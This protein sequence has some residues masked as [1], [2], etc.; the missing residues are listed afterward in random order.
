MRGNVEVA[1]AA[2]KQLGLVT[3]DEIRKAGIHDRSW[4]LCVKSGLWV[5][6]APRVYRSASVSPTFTQRCLAQVLS[7]GSD[8]TI[9]H[10]SAAF[11]LGLDNFREERVIHVTTSDRRV[12][13]R[14]GVRIHRCD[15]LR[16]ADLDSRLDIRITSPVRTIVDLATCSSKRELENAVDSSLRL[17]LTTLDR[18][19][20]RRDVR[21][22][23]QIATLDKVIDGMPNGGLHNRL[24]R[25]FLGLSRRA[26]LPDP[27]GQVEFRE[28]AHTF[29]RAD[30]FY[31][32]LRRVTEVSG[33]RT[34][35]SRQD[36]A[37]D[38]KRHRRLVADGW[39]YLEFT[40]DE[41][42]HEPTNVID[43]LRRFG[44]T[45]S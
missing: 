26:G 39:Q 20:A 5:R 1:L 2:E 3:L 10:R 16:P 18:L 31:D 41:V 11:L 36:R 25:E 22:V 33:H 27:R 38:A 19:S 6:V 40:S 42:F 34:H 29:A 21:R 43:E 28:G 23:P 24:E 45:P 37:A 32:A 15:A 7:L 12:A 35:S 30:F 8:A 9:S 4:Q 14:P 44:T 13:P 17:G